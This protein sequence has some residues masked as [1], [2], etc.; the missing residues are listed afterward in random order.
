MRKR[1]LTQTEILFE[2][3]KEGARSWI[4][5]RKR[6]LNTGVDCL[7]EGARA[8]YCWGA[9]KNFS[10]LLLLRNQT[11]SREHRQHP[12]QLSI[13]I[14]TNTLGFV[15][16]SYLLHMPLSIQFFT[17]PVPQVVTTVQRQ[18]LNANQQQTKYVKN[19]Q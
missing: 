13:V 9:A 11:N 5:L 17:Q 14:L 7:K 18:Q 6:M 15:M 19:A 2:E 3:K 16:L 8:R 12:I 1:M 10:D 4:L